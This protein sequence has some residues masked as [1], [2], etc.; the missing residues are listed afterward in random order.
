MAITKNLTRYP[1][2]NLS[3]VYGEQSRLP[4]Y[5]RKLSVSI[6]DVKTVMKLLDNSETL[7]ID[8]KSLSWIEGFIVKPT[9]THYWV[10]TRT[11]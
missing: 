2:L 4:F 8:K 1:Q 5:Y 6:P 9:L 11:L 10:N 7:G 3:L